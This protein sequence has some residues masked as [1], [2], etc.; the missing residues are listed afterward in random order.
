MSSA[1]QSAINTSKDGTVLVFEDIKLH[2][3]AWIDFDFI[4]AS[5]LVAL[6]ALELALMDRYGLGRKKNMET[7]RSPICCAI[8]RS[9]MA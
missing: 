5:E 4:K 3:L 1:G 9:M 2:L 8:C 6:T 7:W